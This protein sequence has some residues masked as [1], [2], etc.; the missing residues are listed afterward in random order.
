VDAADDIIFN[1]D[2]AYRKR[3]TTNDEWLK[4]YISKDCGTTWVLTKNIHGDD[5]SSVLSTSSYTPQSDEDWYTVDI[6]NISSDYYESDFR[7]KFVFESDNGN[8]IYIDNIN[9]YPSSMAGIVEVDEVTTLNVYP[10]PTTDITNIQ[11]AG[12]EGQEYSITVLNGMG[13]QVHNVYQGGLTDG[14]NT[15]EYNTSDL[16]KGIYIVR[17][18]SE[19]KLQTVKLIKE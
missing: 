6:T 17:I 13:Q 5:L 7:F 4:F 18:E 12:V 9:L 19:G 2:Y 16:A 15:F 10:N 11:I 8:N 1:F 3:Y 14:L